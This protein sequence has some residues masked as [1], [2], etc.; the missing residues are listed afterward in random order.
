MAQSFLTAGGDLESLEKMMLLQEKWERRE[1]EKAFYKASAAFKKTPPKI[2]KDRR[3]DYTSKTG[4]RTQY[5]HA[6]LGNIVELI[7]IELSKH[8]LSSDWDQKQENNQ[9]TVTCYLTHEL[10][11]SKKTSMTSLP[12]TSGGKNGI[13]GLG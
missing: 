13:Q 5:D 3:V 12:D 7:C 8:G 2:F 6:S 1:A 4:V 10:G 11:F 9:L